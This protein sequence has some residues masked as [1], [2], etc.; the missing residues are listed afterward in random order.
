M[1]YG[2]FRCR[3]RAVA[4]SD[5]SQHLVTPDPPPRIQET[6]KL[7]PT[8]D[9]STKTLS[10]HGFCTTIWPPSFLMSV[11]APGWSRST[12]PSGAS[13]KGREVV[14]RSMMIRRKLA[15][16]LSLLIAVVQFAGVGAVSSGSTS[17]A[18]A[19]YYCCCPGECHCTSDCCNHAPTGADNGKPAGSK[20]GAG[21]PILEAPIRCGVWTGTLNRSPDSPKALATTPQGWVFAQPDRSIRRLSESAFIVSPRGALRPSAPRAPP[22]SVE[23]A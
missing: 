22:M 8:H 16:V 12:E 1:I 11:R 23:V 13:N 7:L 4:A 18:S 19:E 5:V 6:L 14:K 3:L 20:I 2:Y 21:T 15:A 17:R 9:F 10:W